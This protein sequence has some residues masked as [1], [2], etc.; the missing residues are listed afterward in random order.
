[1]FVMFIENNVYNQVSHYEPSRKL[2]TDKKTLEI[3]NSNML[4]KF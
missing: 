2:Y 1:M 3:N 4:N